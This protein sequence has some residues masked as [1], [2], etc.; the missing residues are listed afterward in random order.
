MVLINIQISISLDLEDGERYKAIQQAM[1]IIED[2]AIS[3]QD[4]KA[5]EGTN[6][7]KL[8]ETND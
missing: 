1:K 7:Y 4:L 6:V 5:V 3:V 8:K 2:N